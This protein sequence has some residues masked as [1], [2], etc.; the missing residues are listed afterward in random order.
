MWLAQ[1]C[2]D[3][4]TNK[5]HIKQQGPC[6]PDYLL[7]N[8][9]Q[10]QSILWNEEM[11]F[12]SEISQV[13]IGWVPLNSLEGLYMGTTQMINLLLSLP[14]KDVW[15][16]KKKA[17]PK[18]N[19]GNGKREGEREQYRAGR[20]AVDSVNEQSS[21]GW[22]TDR[23]ERNIHTAPGWDSSGR[24]LTTSTEVLKSTPNTCHTPVNPN[25][26]APVSTNWG[27]ENARPCVATALRSR[28]RSPTK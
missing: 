2:S 27:S 3:Q 1:S 18:K 24:P 22:R 4:P 11:C 10:I 13:G 26:N 9:L 25:A 7:C 17:L 23:P 21:T 28:S 8:K 15:V 5:T 14:R 6:A 16:L 12:H 20:D 19:D